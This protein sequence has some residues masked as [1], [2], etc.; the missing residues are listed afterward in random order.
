M[1]EDDDDS[2]TTW[3]NSGRWSRGW[4]G[5]RVTRSGTDTGTGQYW[6]MDGQIV[7]W[8]PKNL[9]DGVAL[10]HVVHDD[11]DEED[12]DE[13][14]AEAAVA[15]FEAKAG[16]GG[17]SAPPV[18]SLAAVDTSGGGP[19]NWS[20]SLLQK[21]VMTHDDGPGV[22]VEVIDKGWIAVKL[23]SGAK[24]KTRPG[25]VK[26]VDDD[27]GAGAAAAV[28][29]VAACG[30]AKAASQGSKQ[31]PLDFLPKKLVLLTP[32]QEGDDSR[33]WTG[34]SSRR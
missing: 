20:H 27:E 14:E 10:W 31:L 23:D 24:I 33:R 21:K 13:A 19:K 18:N 25:N 22:V 15:A 7:G 2:N 8:L 34:S 32:A 16:N 29:A 5:R 17:G 9:N 11:G 4:V 12:L 28:A 26:T 30:E 1:V 3:L 6:E